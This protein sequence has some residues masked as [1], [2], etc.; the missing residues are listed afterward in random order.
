MPA[1]DALQCRTRLDPAKLAQVREVF[2][3]NGVT[4]RDWADANGYSVKLVEELLAGRIHG[5]RG[6][7]HR[8]AVALG[9]KSD[10]IVHKADLRGWNPLRDAN[11]PGVFGAAA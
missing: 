10:N 6:E 9:L 7:A 8:I 4:L 11:R 5:T 3:A 1:D 2:R